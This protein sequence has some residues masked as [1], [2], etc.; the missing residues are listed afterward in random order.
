MLSTHWYPMQEMNRLRNEVDRL[1]GRY[2]NGTSRPAAVAAFPL[3]N[4]WEDDDVLCVEAELPGFNLDDLEIYV[5]GGNQL[6]VSGERKQLERQGGV[7]HRQERGFGK[8]QRTFE[9]PWNVDCDKV[10]A[11]FEHGIL[12]IAMPK[13]AESKPRRIEVKAN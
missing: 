4:M 3:L 8:F 6:S 7:W 11:T 13:S 12:S 5:T 9:L 2:G 1:F 10:S